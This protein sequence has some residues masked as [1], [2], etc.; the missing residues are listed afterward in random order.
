MNQKKKLIIDEAVKLFAQ[1]GYHAASIQEIAEQCGISKGSFYTYF[2]SK[3]DLIVSAFR[4]YYSLLFDKISRLE[5]IESLSPREKFIEQLSLQLHD[6]ISHKEFIHILLSEYKMNISEQLDEFLLK[7][8]SESLL[9]YAK[10][11]KKVYPELPKKY[12]YD[13]VSMLTGIMKEYMFLLLIE[14][15]EI[16]VEAIIPYIMKRMD[17]IVASFDPEDAPLLKKELVKELLEY[18]SKKEIQVKEEILKELDSLG[19]EVSALDHVRFIQTLESIEQ[20][21]LK[22]EPQKVL[23]EALLLLLRKQEEEIPEFTERIRA[24]REQISVMI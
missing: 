8:R 2:K 17:A 7:T 9:W 21:I 16:D 3:E 23:L 20:E 22:K 5:H 1:K 18:R 6:L 19:K 4:S 10:K 11:I 13:C 15:R 12:V 14:E 24:L